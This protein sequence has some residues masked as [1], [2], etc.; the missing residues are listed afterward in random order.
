[1]T[2]L[3][4]NFSDASEDSDNFDNIYQTKELLQRNNYL[5]SIVKH[6]SNLI[7]LYESAGLITDY[8]YDKMLKD[9]DIDDNDGLIDEVS[10]TI[11]VERTMFYDM[12]RIFM[13][14]L[15]K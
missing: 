15:Q 8:D 3:K 10:D 14:K 9:Y 7:G 11:E 13:P 12:L 2:G 1:M 6:D 5:K 4:Q